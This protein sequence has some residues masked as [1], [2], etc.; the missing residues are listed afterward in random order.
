MSAI[1]DIMLVLVVLLIVVLI[2]RGPTMLPKIGES[3]GRTV[4]G[5]RENLPGATDDEVTDSVD[6]DPKPGA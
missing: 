3:F 1:V 4:K 5:V 6:G 2:W